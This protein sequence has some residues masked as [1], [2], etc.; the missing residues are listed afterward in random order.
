MHTRGQ[1]KGRKRR[2]VPYFSPMNLPQ[3]TVTRFVAALGI[4]V[5][6]LG[7]TAWPFALV[8]EWISLLHL[9][10]SYFFTLSG[11]ILII[12]QVRNGQLPETVQAKPFY[13]NRFA[14]IYPLYVL[15]LGLWVAFNLFSSHP[16]DA[17]HW[18]EVGLNLLLLQSWIPGYAISCN[19]PGWSLSVEAFFYAVFPRRYRL[20]RRINTRSVLLSSAVSLGLV[21]CFSGLARAWGMDH[22]FYSYWPL[23]HLGSFLVG[24][25]GGLLFVREYQRFLPYRWVFRISALVLLPAAW[26]LL[27]ERQELVLYAHNGAL[28]PLYMLVIL[29]LALSTEEKPLL[30][31]GILPWLGEISY[32]M[33]ILHIPLSF[34]TYGIAARLGAGVGLDPFWLQLAILLVVSAAS[35]QWIEIPARRLIRGRNRPAPL[36]ETTAE[37][38]IGL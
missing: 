24:V 28:A 10:V 30:G 3:L 19:Y 27:I 34:F 33:Y 20:Y 17:V 18:D 37:R 32:G 6:H 38:A 5:Y 16:A 31:R 9:A 15:A 22:E 11:F 26:M 13:R 8:P 35:Y 36:V 1:T 4:V 23:W 14:R 29:G 25:A 12:A 2:L 21:L 7:R